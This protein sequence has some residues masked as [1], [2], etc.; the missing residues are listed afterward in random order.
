MPVVAA[1][2]VI[3]YAG[4]HGMPPADAGLVFA[5]VCVVGAVAMAVLYGVPRG[6]S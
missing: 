6:A 5:V 1:I 2:V 3:A 4:R